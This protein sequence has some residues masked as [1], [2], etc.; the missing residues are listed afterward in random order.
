MDKLTLL[1]L[2]FYLVCIVHQGVGSISSLTRFILCSPSRAT[3]LVTP[4]LGLHPVT[5]R[6]TQ[7]PR[8]SV[9]GRTPSATH[10]SRRESPSL[11]FHPRPV[12]LRCADSSLWPQNCCRTGNASLPV[13]SHVIKSYSFPFVFQQSCDIQNVAAMCW[14]AENSLSIFFA[15]S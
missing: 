3:L 10:P 8:S 6:R 9:A 15:K 14:R 12:K 1:I 4:H 7:M 13:Y 5:L 11:R 2:S